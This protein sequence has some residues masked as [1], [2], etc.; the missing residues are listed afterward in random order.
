MMMR[1]LPLVRALRAQCAGRSRGI[2]LALL[3]LMWRPSV[4]VSQGQSPDLDSPDARERRLLPML[5][6]ANAM[7]CFVTPPPIDRHGPASVAQRE[8]LRTRLRPMGARVTGV[9]TELQPRVAAAGVRV[10]YLEFPSRVPGAL[11]PAYLVQPRGSARPTGAVM[12]VHG[13]TTTFEEA[14]GWQFDVGAGLGSTGRSAYHGIA[15]SLARA[16]LEVLVPFIENDPAREGLEPW[17]RLARWGSWLSR[18]GRG[19]AQSILLGNLLGGLDFLEDRG[20]VIAAVIGQ[21]EGGSLAMQLA[22]IDTRV[23]G[24]ASLLPPLDRQEL[25]ND[26]SELLRWPTYTQAECGLDDV[27]LARLISPTPLLFANDTGGT[28]PQAFIA[29]HSGPRVTARVRAAYDSSARGRFAA[30]Q[31]SGRAELHRGVA[32]WAAT[33]L[34]GDPTAVSLEEPAIPGRSSL[35]E[36]PQDAIARY[37]EAVTAAVFEG[38]PAQL[39]AI[40][41][42]V[43]NRDAFLAAIEPAR[44]AA[45][46]ELT[47]I[48]WADEPPARVTGR[49]TVLV[50]DRYVL[51]RLH[52]YWARRDLRFDA[53]LATPRNANGRVPL[54]FSTDLTLGA[55]ELF[56]LPPLGR[57]EYLGAYGDVLAR[58]GFAV[59]APIVEPEVPN[60]LTPLWRARDPRANGAWSFFLP[61]YRAALGAAMQQVPVDPTRVMAY[62]ISFA[63]YGALALT[64]FDARI[65]TLVY[66]NPAHVHELQFER[67]D[68]DPAPWLSDGAAVWDLIERYLI[69]P[70]RFIREVESTERFELRPYQRVG[71]IAELYELLGDA[72]RFRFVAQ[73]GGHLTNVSG[74]LPWLRD[75]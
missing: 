18:E 19:G 61:F 52:L 24:V 57:T 46:R 66:S 73:P 12:L 55:N 17:P 54:V 22:A 69:Y 13:T 75:H 56:G 7:P 26:I 67:R 28:A 30:R 44:R 38:R 15:L 27:V 47:G 64:A 33:T 5:A 48:A 45:W 40:R 2:A 21:R 58:E 62:G 37:R 35:D 10:S 8:W 25:R 20:H 3:V 43:R 1:T 39:L 36:Y 50:T 14:M 11:V 34:G 9:A 41:P 32:A 23:A 16:G 65:T 4:A 31:F 74:I 72:Q 29:R 6:M 49:D 53:L 70:R 68:I 59:F 71:E 51:E 60:L 42:D 63:G